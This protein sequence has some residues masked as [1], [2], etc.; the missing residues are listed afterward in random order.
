MKRRHRWKYKPPQPKRSKK[1]LLLSL[2]G[3]LI[4]VCVVIV[5][6]QQRSRRVTRE[7]TN[8]QGTMTVKRGGDFQKALDAA[9]PGDTIFLEAGA[10]FEGPFTLPKK[11]GDA[12]ITIRTSAPDSSLP[13]VDQR[14]TPAYASALPKLVTAGKGE[15]ALQTA[16]GAHHYRFIGVEIK[17]SDAE[18]LVYDLV[19]LG[20]NSKAQTTLAQ[21]PHHFILD[22]CYIHGDPRGSLKRGLA[23]HSAQTEIINSYI[24]DF[25]VKGQEAQAIWG[26]NGPGPFK[27]VNNYLEGAGENILFGGEDPT[28]PNLVPT[29]IEI[30]RN[31]LTK[32]VNWRGQFT[33]KN[34]LELKNARRVVI[35]ANLLEYNWADAQEGVAV[36]FT[37]RNQDGS[38]PWSA[39][40]DITFTNNI[41][42]HSGSAFFIHGKD[43]NHPSQQTRKITIRNNLF[44]DISRDNWG[45][46]GAFLLVTGTIDLLIEQN[47]VLQSGNIT[48]AYGDVNTGFIFRNNVIMDNG[49]GFHG[50]DRSPGQDTL[51]FYFPGSIVSNNAIIN[52]NASLYKGRNMYPAS[53]DYRP[54]PDSPLKRAGTNGTDIGANLDP[55][56]FTKL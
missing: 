6:A 26:A 49:Y 51:D 10:S 38:A 46:R 43:N 40:E 27:I 2:V 45:G 1:F 52:G 15:A 30:R 8:G 22:R 53:A 33:V 9:Q 54:R 50:D 55:Q 48:A 20:E 13:G 36:L 42:R 34:L 25:K 37:V 4:A 41:V 31:H 5:F 29:D 24:S 32:P 16:A 7:E 12:Y 3:A 23:L 35:D 21:V 47:T 14:I 11:T 44:E 19:K 39:V 18:A 17:P 56:T 28:I